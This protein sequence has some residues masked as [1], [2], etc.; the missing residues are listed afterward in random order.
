MPRQKR[1]DEAGAIY[2]AL[3]RGNRRQTIFQKAGDYEAFL[4]VLSQGLEKYPVELFSFVLMP[5]HWHLVL[6]PTE[7]G[8]M[9]RLLRWVTATHTL[10]YHAHY[11][12]SGEGH[13]YQA[14]FKSFPVEN[15][16]H[17]LVLCRYA[18]RN[19]LRAGLVERA[20]DW[21]YSSLWEW[22]NKPRER[23]LVSPWP[24]PR[25]ANWVERV[26]KALTGKELA[27]VR[28]C[29]E[30][31]RPFGSDAWVQKVAQSAGLEYTL[32]PIGRPSKSSPRP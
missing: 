22:L 12:T 28:T 13:L 30:R 1:A 6:R 32:R 15:D 8:G 2:H 23:Q 17:F 3:N 18:E 31:G 21:T 29:V 4:R 10:R 20:E 26:N 14:R 25:T 11:H 19:P 16:S 27:A 5:N 7:D 24:I 9:G